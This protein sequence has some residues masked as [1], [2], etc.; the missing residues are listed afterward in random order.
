MIRSAIIFLLLCFCNMNFAQKNETVFS[1]VHEVVGRNEL[2]GTDIVAKQYKFSRRIF[3]SRIDT[4]LGVLMIQLRDTLKKSGN[5]KNTGQ[6]LIYDVNQDQVL[7]NKFLNYNL[8]HVEMFGQFVIQS[9]KGMSEVYFTIA[10]NKIREDFGR[11]MGVYKDINLGLVV[12]CDISGDPK[13]RLLGVNMFSGEKL[14]ERKMDH[15]Y[16]M[17][18]SVRLNDS[19]IVVVSGGLHG[20][21]LNNGKGW[22]YDLEV[23]RKNYSASIFG[24]LAGLMVGILSRGSVAFFVVGHDVRNMHS[25]LIVSDSAVYMA[26]RKEIVRLDMDGNVVWKDEMVEDVVTMSSIF[27]KDGV[28]Y[29]V[30]T[31]EVLRNQRAQKRGKSFLAAFDASSG[32]RKFL[33]LLGEDNVFTRYAVKDSSVVL[34]QREG[35][36]VHALA[37]QMVLAKM[38][39][40]TSVYGELL[41]FVGKKIYTDQGNYFECLADIDSAWINVYTS[42]KRVLTMDASLKIVAN[43]EWDDF[44]IC[45]AEKDGYKFLLKDGKTIVIDKKNRKVADINVNDNSVIVGKALHNISKTTYSVIDLS[46][47]IEN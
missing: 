45:Y 11:Y 16:G 19:V 40:D 33:T 15:G 7:W 21:N 35:L 2:S 23:G 3:V 31:G 1:T 8:D 38:S 44:Y 13:K 32:K 39:C 41:N 29:M 25:N 30:N 20:V 47:V 12:P 34:L 14:W 28:L 17:K 24:S 37:D 46:S 6:M 42:K 22:D 10:G 36:Q 9:A 43:R 4:T 5:Y 26:G 18:D 27:V